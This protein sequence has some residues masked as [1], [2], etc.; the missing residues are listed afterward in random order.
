MKVILTPEEMKLSAEIGRARNDASIGA[1]YKDTYGLS[2]STAL[3]KHIE[4]A[5]G[6]CAAAKALGIKWQADVHS[7]G[8]G[9]NKSDV[10]KYE[11]R[12]TPRLGGSLILHDEDKDDRIYILVTGKDNVY[13]VRGWIQC[14]DG[15]NKNYW[16]TDVR[17]PA[18]FVPQSALNPIMELEQPIQ[19]RLHL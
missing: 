3:Q 12:S 6:E 2:A 9:L 14:K 19:M 15:K 17:Y 16:R 11:V 5:R 4:G 1:G 18:Y 7:E 8:G 10:G 13:F